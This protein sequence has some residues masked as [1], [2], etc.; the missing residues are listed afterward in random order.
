MIGNSA[1]VD[2]CNVMTN[3]KAKRPV[4]VPQGIL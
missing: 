3:A 4:V 1:L 2:K